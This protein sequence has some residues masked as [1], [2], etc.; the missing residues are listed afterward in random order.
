MS[1]SQFGIFDAA[2][3]LARNP[4]GIIALFI[5]LVYGFASLVTAFAGAFTHEE[6]LPL[7]YFLVLFPGVVLAVFAWLVNIHGGKLLIMGSGSLAARP[8]RCGIDGPFE[9]GLASHPVSL[10]IDQPH[11]SVL[12]ADSCVRSRLD[13]VHYSS[14]SEPD[15]VRLPNEN[16]LLDLDAQGNVVAITLEL[17][18]QRADAK[19]FSFEQVAAQAYD[20]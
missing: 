13:F 19:H 2:K 3:G 14:G 10:A 20:G 12:I 5:V 16:T 18:S 7:I 9:P 15:P 17:A 11:P 6:R 8:Y 1:D 4:L